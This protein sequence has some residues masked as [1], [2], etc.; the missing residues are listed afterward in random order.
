MNTPG[1][2]PIITRSQVVMTGKK[3]SEGGGV[4]HAIADV[5]FIGIENPVWRVFSY[6]LYDNLIKTVDYDA[7]FHKPLVTETPEEKQK[8]LEMLEWW[9]VIK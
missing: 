3:N 4:L 9:S 2:E 8:A 1:S 7:R 6:D 5:Y